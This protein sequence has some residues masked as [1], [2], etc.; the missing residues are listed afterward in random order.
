MTARKPADP[1]TEVQISDV[2]RE[3]E[4]GE[5]QRSPAE[6]PLSP[7][8]RADLEDDA[9]GRHKNVEVEIGPVDREDR[10]DP[11]SEAP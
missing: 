1:R 2:T 11:L 4:H 10:D 5:G 8:P 9:E 7:D 6:E 3:R